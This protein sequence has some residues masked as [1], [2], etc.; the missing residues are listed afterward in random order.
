MAGARHGGA[1]GF[2][3]RLVPALGR[4]GLEQRAVIRRHETRARELTAGDIETIEVPFGGRL[5]WTTRR[6]LKQ[7]IQ[8]Y[9]PD[10]VMTWM[11]RAARFCPSGKHVLV[12]RLGGYYDLKYYRHCDHLIV[13]TKD[14]RTYL[15]GEG[16]PAERA[17]HIPNFVDEER[18]SAVPR[19]SLG[20]PPDVPLLLALGRLHANKAF[21]V[22]LE[23][24]RDLPPAWLWIA[25]EGPLEQNLRDQAARLGLSERVRFLGWRDDTAALLGA[26]DILVCPSRHEPLGNVVLEAWAHR[27]PVVAAASQGPS[28]LIEDKITGLLAPIDDPRVLAE[29]LRGAIEMPDETAALA[30]RGYAAY[31]AEYTE[32]RVVKRYLEFVERLT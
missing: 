27:T 22:L 29:T 6:T 15:L 12:G 13:N 18:R 21:D 19:D 3:M 2:F 17:W 10:L 7:A 20:T 28:E 30:L 16:W 25:G 14:L 5:D 4:A 31:Q 32:S 26:A 8:A 11:S 9:R 23:A 24:M 1:E